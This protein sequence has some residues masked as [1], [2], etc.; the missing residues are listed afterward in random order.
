MALQRAMNMLLYKALSA[1]SFD[2]YWKKLIGISYY[3]NKAIDPV[4]TM[5][6][7]PLQALLEEHNSF[8]EKAKETRERVKLLLQLADTLMEKGHAHAP[9][10]K[11]WVEEVD[12][13]YKDFSTRMDKYRVKLEAHLGISSASDQLSL[14]RTSVSSVDSGNATASTSR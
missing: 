6:F 11:S 9:S 4:I 12:D 13:T 3:E 1:P 14:D 10:I 5:H 8:K 7:S 2:H